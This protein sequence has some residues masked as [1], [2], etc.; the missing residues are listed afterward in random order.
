MFCCAGRG[1]GSVKALVTT[2]AVGQS[3]LSCGTTSNKFHLSLIDFLCLANTAAI[4]NNFV[5]CV[6][7]YG[8]SDQPLIS[9]SYEA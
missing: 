6:L 3:A 1:R 8:F 9:G 4:Q 7:L 5:K 2:N